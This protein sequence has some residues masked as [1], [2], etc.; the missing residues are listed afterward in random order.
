MRHISEWQV[1][2]NGTPDPGPDN[3]TTDCNTAGEGPSL[4][5]TRSG[6]VSARGAF[7]MLGNLAEWV[8]DWVLASTNCVGLAAFSDDDMCLAGASTTSTFPGAWLRG[9][10]FVVL[11]GPLAGPFAVR[12]MPPSLRARSFIGFRCARSS[13]RMERHS[14]I[15]TD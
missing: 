15:D 1:A 13:E 11:G 14:S 7:D 10:A 5:G 6:C 8:A 9:G 2:A 3:G 4:T 12:D